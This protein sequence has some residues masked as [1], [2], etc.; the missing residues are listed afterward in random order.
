MYPHTYLMPSGKIFM[1][2]NFS[3]ILWDHVNNVETYLP[4]M[5]GRVI[6]VYP[7]SAAVAMLPLTP[8][9]KYTPPSSSAVEAS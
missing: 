2:A 5:P 9:N 1:Q 8:Q 3:T 4:D 6:R 7:A